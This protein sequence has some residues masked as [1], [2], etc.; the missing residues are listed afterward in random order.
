MEK[1][2]KP[3]TVDVGAELSEKFSA[4]VTRLGSLKGRAIE[5]AIKAFLALPE[6]AQ[7]AL[8]RDG[9]ANDILNKAFCQ[10]QLE[11]D[12]QSLPEAQRNQLLALAKQ[13]A[14]TIAP[15]KKDSRSYVTTFPRSQ[16]KNLASSAFARYVKGHRRRFQSLNIG[17]GQG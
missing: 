7:T 17:T 10:A 4:Q 2:K 3:F 1:S 15:K 14:K 9:D 8:M 6:D 16:S 12:L 13:A 5:A 11:A